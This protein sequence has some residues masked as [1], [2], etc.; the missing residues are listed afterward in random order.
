MTCFSFVVKCASVQSGSATWFIKCPNN[1][2]SAAAFRGG[3]KSGLVVAVFQR[4]ETRCYFGCFICFCSNAKQSAY[5]NS[6]G[7]YVFIGHKEWSLINRQN[8]L[9]FKPF[10]FEW[11]HILNISNKKGTFFKGV[12]GIKQITPA[13]FFV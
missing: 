4:K 3:G 7:M 8:I 12:L 5:Q 1:I 6:R 10:L 13:L 2:W 11:N 9:V